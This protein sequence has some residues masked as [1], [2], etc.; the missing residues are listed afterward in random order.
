MTPPNTLSVVAFVGPETL[1]LHVA[2]LHGYYAREGLNVRWEAATGSIDQM[3]RLIEGDCDMVMT[4]IDNIIAYNA[5]Q[6]GVPVDPLPDLVAFLGCASEPRPLMALPEISGL[7]GLRGRRIAV[8][9]LNTG[10]SFLLRQLLQDS[11]PG[12]K[13]YELV[14]VGAPPARWQ[15]MQAGDC[16]AALLSKAFAAIAVAAGCRELRAEPDPW[17]NYQGGVFAARRS[18]IADHANDVAGFIRATLAATGWILDT[19]NRAQLPDLLMAHL[20]HMT[21]EASV[22]AAGNMAGLLARDLPINPDGL[23]SVIVLRQTYGSP[24]ATLGSPDSYLDL[25]IYDQVAASR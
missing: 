24:P 1:P 11:G 18:W 6:G 22:E 19:A 3:V 25:S 10:F 23:R 4:A 13:D 12:M 8:D 9:A 17:A 7:A 2:A 21:R 14:P 5:G 16:A 20:P 15:S